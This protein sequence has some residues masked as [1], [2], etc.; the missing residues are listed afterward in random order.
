MPVGAR[1]VMVRQ[2][3]MVAMEDVGAKRN[4]S[5]NSGRMVSIK[6]VADA[7]GVSTATVSRVL[8]GGRY[9]RPEVRARVLATVNALGYRPNL[10][11]RSLRTQH[12]NSIGLI[13]SD[14]RNPFFTAVSRAVEDA[15]YA[16]GFSVLLCNTDEDPQ[17][18][19]IYLDLLR[20]AQVAGVIFSPTRHA[21]AQFQ[22]ARRDMPMVVVD[23][24]IPNADVDSVL[25]DNVDA[26]YQLT[27][28]LLENGYRRIGALFGDVSTTGRDR[29]HGYE[30]ALRAHGLV[31][32]AELVRSVRPTMEA[33]HTATLE[34][35]E[36]VPPLDALF[37][38]NSLL[39]AGAMLAIRERR[40]TIPHDLALVS[41]DETTW[42]ALVDP[43]ITLI[44][45]PTYEIGQAAAE[46]LLQRVA[47]PRRP[48][49]QVL[50]K[51]QLVVRPSSA[52]RGATA[53][54]G[55]Q[56]GG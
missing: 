12:A 1:S 28:H 54:P 55:G 43:P 17:K 13:V 19:A 40:L 22:T 26:A 38:S 21:M 11:A 10:V 16:Q 34:L 49:R 29:R 25:L 30:A 32:A 52:P 27:S 15:A 51:G 5:G 7:A 23:R 41:F 50:F 39:A 24:S 6:E 2:K 37:A 44:A 36:A 9:V 56:T 42:E 48:P 4:G 35:L 46:L 33:G 47:D 45:Q 53:S 3:G 18:E 8:A 14:I 31:P 20:D